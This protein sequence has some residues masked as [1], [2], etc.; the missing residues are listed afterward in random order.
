MLLNSFKLIFVHCLLL[1]SWFSLP[2][3][4]AEVE[5]EDK[6][7]ST[8][9]LWGYLAALPSLRLTQ[10]AP[11]SLARDLSPTAPNRPAIVSSVRRSVQLPC[12]FARANA[13][14]MIGSAQTSEEHGVPAGRRDP[15]WTGGGGQ[16][17]ASSPCLRLS[18]EALLIQ[19]RVND[20]LIIP[21][22]QRARLS[23]RT[24][25]SKFTAR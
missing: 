9:C 24:L 4:S 15:L 14:S 6:S 25:P 12:T 2:L 22:L 1:K 18:N 5:E 20:Y 3:G 7:W 10:N 8:S 21:V 17:R 13:L 16:F 11:V 23:L 19:I